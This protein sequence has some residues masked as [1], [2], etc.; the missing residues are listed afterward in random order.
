MRSFAVLLKNGNLCRYIAVGRAGDTWLSIRDKPSGRRGWLYVFG[1]IYW[2]ALYH[3]YLC[4][5]FDGSA[6]GGIGIPGKKNT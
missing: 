5:R 6:F 3:F 1:T 4:W 2:C